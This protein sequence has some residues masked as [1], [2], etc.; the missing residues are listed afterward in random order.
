MLTRRHELEWFDV[1]MTCKAR[2]NVVQETLSV[3]YDRCRMHERILRVRFCNWFSNMCMMDFFI[4][5]WHFSQI[6]LIISR[7]MLT[8]NNRYWSSE[9]PHALIQLPLYDQKIGICCAISAN[10]I[11]GPIF[12]EGT[13]DAERCMNEI[14][15]PLFVNV[16]P[17]EERFGYFMQDGAS[18]HTAKESIRALRGVSRIKCGRWNYYQDVFAYPRSKTTVLKVSA[19]VEH[20]GAGTDLT[21]ISTLPINCNVASIWTLI[22]GM[23]ENST[24]CHRSRCL[25]HCTFHF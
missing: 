15:N 22:V 11:I 5:S 9:N 2:T 18:P 13:L 1:L 8:Q 6:R 16:A 21:D 17:A 25:K 3:W 23:G 19:T 7:D 14:L 10:D 24:H 4:L 20:D 12:Y